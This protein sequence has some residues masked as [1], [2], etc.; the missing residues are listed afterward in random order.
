MDY[1]NL[2]STGLKISPLCL[3]CMTYG[4]P[5]RGNH[6]WTMGEEESRPLLKKAL[7]MGI[8]FFDTANAYSDGTSEEIVGRALKDFAQR[9]EIVLATK[10][11]F[12]MR[13]K[14][15]VGG[16]SRKAIFASI[17]ASLKRLGTDYVDLY[18]IHR[19]DY[20]TPI[21]E[22]MEALHDVVKAGK[23][24]H[25]GA[26]SMYAWQFAKALHVADRNGW[27][28]FVTMQNYVNLLYRE[29]EREMLPLCRDEGIGVIPWSPMARGRLTR[30]WDT[31]SARVE[32]DEFGKSLYANTADA[33]RRVVERVA[34]IANERGV[35][36]AQVALAWVVQ[37]TGISAPIIGASKPQH[38]EDAVAALSLNLTTEEIARLEEPYVPHGVV[39]FA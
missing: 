20:E 33:D 18:Q 29:E 36:R 7:D 4:V 14:P 8:N 34:E 26:S 11:Y 1:K 22:T 3:G 10:V 19:W 15:N 24:L 17:D 32:S 13:N 35:P 5:E 37:K 28:R 39:G 2:G 21:E 27:T 31:S 30:D 12:P 9:D 38:L 25:I 6:P 16:L 23:A